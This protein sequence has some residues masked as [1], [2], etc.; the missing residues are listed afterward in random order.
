MR[1]LVLSGAVTLLALLG[2]QP[3]SAQVWAGAGWYQVAY[4]PNG[5]SLW[6]GPY[7]DRNTCEASLPASDDYAD[8]GCDH[9]DSR[10]DWGY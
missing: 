3:A 4:T 7:A 5:R 6:A 2:A 8:Y 9:F 1:R 10:P